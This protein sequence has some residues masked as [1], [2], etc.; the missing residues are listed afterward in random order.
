LEVGTVVWVKGLKLRFRLRRGARVSRG[1]LLKVRVG[2]VRLVLRVVDFEPVVLLSPSEVAR[3][4][5][6]VE[7]GR[8]VVVLDRDVRLYDTAVGVVVVEVGEDGV[9]RGPSCAPPLF[10]AVETL[11]EGDLRDLNLDSGDLRIGYLRVGHAATDA[12]V[13]LRGD[14]VIPHHVL[15]SGVTG[16][17][18]SNFGKVLA[19]AV[20]SVEEPRYSLVLFD[21]ESEYFLGGSPGSLGLA[22]LPQAE[23]RLFYVS[24]S[25]DEASRVRV[26]FEFDGATVARSILAHPLEVDVRRLHPLDFI[27]TGEF[28]APQEELLWLAWRAFGDDWLPTLLDMP[29]SALYSR[30][31]KMVHRNTINT[32]KRKLRH[33]L[34]DG[35]VFK[36]GCETDLL[37]AVVSA[38]ARG[39]VV[40]F[41]I[42]HASEGEEKLLSVAVARRIFRAYER[43]KKRAP[44]E[45]ERLPYVLI[46]VEEAHRYLSRDAL[47]QHGEVRENIFSVISK[48]GRKY[49]VGAMYIT[50][51][52]GDLMEP[53]IRQALTKVILP[54]PTRPDY[55]KVIQ[56]SP[57]LEDAEDEI[58]TLDRGEALIVSPASGLRFAVPV[59]VFL[60]EDLARA[61]LARELRL[62]ASARAGARR[63]VR[64]E[65]WA[66]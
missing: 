13:S 50:Q 2:D 16:S 26:T 30:L 3:L 64:D 20:M 36:E 57:Y 33:M 28:S 63:R 38:V 45:W 27:M 59:K 44:E 41:D 62:R 15:V 56:Y 43:L 66:V 53:V 6:R 17:G 5:K 24:S 23:E 37:R 9:P 55:L 58:K 29:S 19:Y 51:M 12:V 22:H 4:S 32:V 25:V 65:V 39:K 61:E 34:G 48:R 47:T 18:K 52:P 31:R 21:C 8:E 40:L 42:P 7:E 54:L 46:A 1:Q 35:H 11:D 60:F 10:S 49:K 14:R